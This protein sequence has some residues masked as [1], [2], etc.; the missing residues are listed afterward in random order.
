MQERK[1]KKA[2]HQYWKDVQQDGL[3]ALNKKKL[4][5]FP[6]AK[7]TKLSNLKGQIK[8]PS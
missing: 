5:Q 4:T 2:N 1:I 6:V 3:V 8:S 7:R